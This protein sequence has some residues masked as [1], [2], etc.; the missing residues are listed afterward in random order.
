MDW[1]LRMWDSSNVD[2]ANPFLFHQR[3]AVL[4]V[5]DIVVR[6]HMSTQSDIHAFGAR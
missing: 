4:S 5:R 6:L 2:V 1:R 3:P